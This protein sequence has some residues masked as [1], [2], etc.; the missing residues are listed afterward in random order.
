MFAALPELVFSNPALWW[1]SVALAAPFLI[2]LLTRRTVKVIRFP[3]MQ[4]LKQAKAS[5]SALFKLR[6]LILLLV[7]TALLLALLLAFLKPILTAR[8]LK[9]TSQAS[10]SA[11][12]LILDRS[13][14]MALQGG[15]MSPFARGKAA[16]EKIIDDLSGGDLADLVLAGASA[17]SSFDQPSDNRFHLR[18]DL[19]RAEVLMERCDGKLALSEAVK[20]LEKVEGYQKEIHIISDFQRAN[21]AGLNFKEIPN[22]VK[23]VFLSVA[24]EKPVNI[25]LTEVQIVPPVPSLAEE[26]E[27]HCKV[28]NFSDFPSRI[29][30]T[31]QL[32]QQNVLQRDV[33]V[34]ARSTATALFRVR[35][36]KKGVFEG[37]A[38][39][40]AD[41]LNVDNSRYFTMRVAQQLQVAVLTDEAANDPAASHRFLETALNPWNAKDAPI[42]SRRATPLTLDKFLLADAQVLL[43]S[44]VSEIP[45]K[46]L[47]LIHTWAAAGGSVIYFLTG[48]V[49]KNNLLAWN[50]V[51][52]GELNLPFAPGNFIDH[53]AGGRDGSAS[54]GQAN[55]DLPMLRAFKETSDL[56]EPRFLKYFA[57]ERK[58][59]FGQIIIRY[60]D[61]N[62][63]LARKDI[64]AGSIL[65]A[66]FGA[67]LRHSDLAR[68]TL[69]V[70]FVHE[71]V[72]GMRPQS[73][74]PEFTVGYAASGTFPLE[75]DGQGLRFLGPARQQVNAAFEVNQ[76]QVSV[77]FTATPQPGNY[78]VLEKEKQVGS[79]PVNVDARESNPDSLT[80]E[81]LEELS[82]G[83][84]QRF[85][86]RAE[87]DLTELE[88]LRAGRPIW[89]YC[90]AAVLALV[91]AELACA[92]IWK[93]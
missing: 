42:L 48:P 84:N 82:R 5:N 37:V 71:L 41:S 72:R 73:S 2:H 27:I 52:E 93:R 28:A 15:P 36:K 35:P 38:S 67:G 13:A 59:G 14:S 50:T 74:P 20:K 88:E 78:W 34:P 70:P 89:H 43:V 62:V 33:D 11:V 47:E 54:F 56:G 40:P 32:E 17:V 68:K 79:V 25:A 65:L 39:I 44:G 45:P 6:H 29:P 75:G 60:D 69:F 12:V 21:W 77:F 4:F 9:T 53:S 61:Q 26:V 64:G 87:G 8:T 86:S 63:A 23:V 31:L 66:N 1:G 90:M 92:A 3:A 91:A 83:T 80:L 81:Q 22:D 7:R 18:S 46:T 85:F 58:A 76:K 57:T 10:G 19:A 30:V 24:L 16:A 49:D 51:A 55:F